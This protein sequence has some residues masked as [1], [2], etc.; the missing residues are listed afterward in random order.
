MASLDLHG[1]TW[2]EAREELVRAYNE[3]VENGRLLPFEVIHG[4]GASGHG[5]VLQSA[6]RTFLAEN[7]IH[8]TPGEH[9]DRN[10]GHT[11]VTPGAPLPLLGDRLQA[12]ILT[13]CRTPRTRSEISGRFRRYGE[14]EIAA[15]LDA[16]RAA[17]RLHAVADKGR[18]K[19][20]AA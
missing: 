2:A 9:Y 16:L 19:W 7:G 17:K 5:S 11:M 3:M 10:P 20:R 13:Y 14:R 6:V 8:F 1:L 15:A 12:G 18:K 4:Y